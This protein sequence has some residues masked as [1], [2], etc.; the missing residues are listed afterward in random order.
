MRTNIFILLL[1]MNLLLNSV[2]AE[3]NQTMVYSSE[4]DGFVRLSS[5][6]IDFNLI[7]SSIQNK[8]YQY[9]VVMDSGIPMIEFGDS[10]ALFLKDDK[11]LILIDPAKKL[12]FEGISS[13]GRLMQFIVPAKSYEATSFLAENSTRY[14]PTNLS[15]LTLDAPWVEGVAGAGLGESLVLSWTE[16][17][18]AIV[19]INGF[20]SMKKP[21]LYK[22]NN[23]VERLRILLDAESV[24]SVYSL[25]DTPVPQVLFL[26]K[27]ARRV[28]ITIDSVYAGDRWDDTC[29]S[30]IQGINA[31]AEG[32]IFQSVK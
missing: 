32:I 9:R 4:I 28:V 25:V 14:L 7:D 8:R 27:H 31:Y 1:S 17:V 16:P 19:I 10:K 18:F 29:L 20:I 26:K 21:Y 24:E 13:S 3:E 22:A 6:Y 23:R 12:F 15:F 30:M 2:F 11:Y 5:E